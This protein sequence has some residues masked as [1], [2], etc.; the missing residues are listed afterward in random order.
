MKKWIFMLMLAVMVLSLAAC[1]S[2][3]KP[4]ET[5]FAA[6]LAA[7]Y[8]TLLVEQKA[9]GLAMEELTD[10]YL[11]VFYP[12]LSGIERRQSVIYTPL[13]SATAYEVAMVEVADPDDTEAVRAIFQNR[14]DDQVNGGAWYPETV[15]VWE[16]SAEI[17]VRDN[18]VCLFVGE[19]KDD[20][21]A[22]FNALGETE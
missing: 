6:D 18:Y 4:E 13:I 1:G 21:V 5:P 20:M 15:E 11:D 12:G 10:E 14:I 9:D 17:V 8:D 3:A 2:T 19:C 16:N 22:A 7:F